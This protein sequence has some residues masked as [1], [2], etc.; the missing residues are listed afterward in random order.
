MWTTMA[1]VLSGWALAALCL[2][3]LGASLG[4]LSRLPGSLRHDGFTVFWLGWA[5]LLAL[6]QLW[7][8]VLPVDGRATLLVLS[9]GLAGTAWNLP[10]LRASLRR[11]ARHPAPLAVFLAAAVGMANLAL[12]APRNADAGA[13]FLP[14]LRWVS[15]YPIVPGLGNLLDRLAFNQTYFLYAAVLDAG[16]FDHRAHHLANGLLLLAVLGRSLHGAFQLPRVPPHARARP[17][18]A[19]LFLPATVDQIL[20]GDYTSLAADTAIFALGYAAGDL[21]LGL[22]TS[23]GRPRTERGLVGCIALLSAVGLTVKLSW[24]GLGLPCY[25]LAL[26]VWW[27]RRGWHRSA[28]RIVL[29]QATLLSACVLLP[30]LAR[31][32]LWTGYPAYPSPLGGLAVDWRVPRETVENL[33]DYIRAWGRRPGVPVRLALD[34]WDW[35]GPWARSLLLLNWEVL[36]PVTLFLGSMLGLL[37]RRMRG[38]RARTAGSP[39]SLLLLPPAAGLVFW[40]LGSPDPRF[41]GACFWLLAAYALLLVLHAFTGLQSRSPLQLGLVLVVLATA[42]LFASAT[43]PAPYRGDGFE[44]LPPPATKPLRTDWGL[45]VEVGQCWDGP[46]PCSALLNRHLRLRREGD[47]SSGFQVETH[48]SAPA[49]ETA[50]HFR[51][52]P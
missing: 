42:S 3:G 44:P 7:H 31:G 24:V 34:N 12:Y 28:A 26:G 48:P 23:A 45:V 49:L 11:V 38:P 4:R 6:L 39:S 1:L 29:A 5:L 21:L 17:L 25:V 50:E 52:Y 30:W 43:T 36:F 10:T 33:T 37:L 47:L 41:A 19:A 20:G 8:L 14:T 46:L 22:V 51:A 32:V 18:F 27:A 40:F 2:W 16:P 13:Y 35:L 15:T 9:L